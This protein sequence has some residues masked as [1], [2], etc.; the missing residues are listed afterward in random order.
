MLA[1]LL[2]LNNDRAPD[3]LQGRANDLRWVLRA[4]RVASGAVLAVLLG[5]LAG[6]IP[7]AGPALP[8]LALLIVAS[9]AQIW[10]L[11]GRRAAAAWEVAEEAQQRIEQMWVE[12]EQST[13][14]QTMELTEQNRHLAP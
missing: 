13:A 11:T 10:Q 6:W 4:R 7:L 2:L 3:D 1:R 14:R 5:A 8:A 9:E 12:H